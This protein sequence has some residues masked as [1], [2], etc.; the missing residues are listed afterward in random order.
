MGAVSLRRSPSGVMEPKTNMYS[1]QEQQT[2]KLLPLQPLSRG[3]KK[4][5]NTEVVVFADGSMDALSGLRGSN[6]AL[7][8]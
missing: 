7:M 6:W 4:I 2:I 5:S 3:K 1:Y 8:H